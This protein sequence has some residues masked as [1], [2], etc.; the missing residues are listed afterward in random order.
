M[1]LHHWDTLAKLLNALLPEEEKYK[2]GLLPNSTLINWYKSI[3][4][5]CS[6]AS[7]I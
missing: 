6:Y 2:G 5:L 4:L 7:V 1:P 3:V